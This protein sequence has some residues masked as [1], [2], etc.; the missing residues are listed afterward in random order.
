MADKALRRDS[1]NFIIQI[2]KRSYIST[3]PGLLFVYQF[4]PHMN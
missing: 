3:D 1:N 4:I 2:I